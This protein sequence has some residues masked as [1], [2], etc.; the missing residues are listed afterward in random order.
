MSG[1]YEWKR[2][3]ARKQPF[4]IHHPDL[5]PC[6]LRGPVGAWHDLGTFTIITTAANAALR[7]VHD[8]MPLILAPEEQIDGNRRLRLAITHISDQPQGPL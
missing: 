6:P 8:R 1:F 5:Q 4:A 7:A 3:G 2:D